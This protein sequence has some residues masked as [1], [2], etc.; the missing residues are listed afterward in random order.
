MT[1]SN[2]ETT[3]K[4]FEDRM[5]Q[6]RRMLKVAGVHLTQRQVLEDV[7]GKIKDSILKCHECSNGDVC[8]TWLE[9]AVEGALPPEFCPNHDT[10]LG[11][12]TKP[13][14]DEANS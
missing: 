14:E 1:K 12:I 2:F 13:Q 9:T 7:D 4:A 11:L 6:R 5:A 10:F 8:M 3:I